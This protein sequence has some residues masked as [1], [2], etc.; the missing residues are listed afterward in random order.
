MDVS[1][2]ISGKCQA[3]C[4][5]CLQDTIRKADNN[6]SFVTPDE[7]SAIINKLKECNY[8]SKGMVI[9]LY[10]WGE[11]L[12]NPHINEILEI[13][14][15]EGC[16]ACLSTNFIKSS[17]I[18][19]D[20]IPVIKHFIFSIS[21]L[22]QES[23]SRIH[24]AD[25]K[26]VLNNFENFHEQCVTYNPSIIIA[27]AWH[28]YR[29][30]EHEFWDAF[31]YFNRRGLTFRPTVAYIND[32]DKFIDFINERSDSHYLEKVTSDLHADYL[33]RMVA[34]HAKRS[35]HYKCP[36]WDFI[37]VDDVSNLMLCC[38]VF[39]NNNDFVLGNVFE[40]SKDEIYSRRLNHPYCKGCIASGLARFA[41]N[42][43]IGGLHDHP[44]PPGNA[45]DRFALWK[46]SNSFKSILKSVLKLNPKVYNTVRNILRSR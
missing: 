31:H 14:K 29:F 16:Y 46:R 9:N 36:A 42:Q 32:M 4:P 20:L 34:H 22:S 3:K 35:K 39:R 21:G 13:I 8:L 7:F 44:W 23:Y 37:T 15:Q 43:S 19:P 1:I 12:L 38:G 2:E 26:S 24:G 33:L 27:V 11:P 40:M 45:T 28:R 5:H 41:Y 30:N 10:H 18:R 6:L 17:P 25:L